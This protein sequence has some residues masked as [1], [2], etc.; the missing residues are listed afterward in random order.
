MI[1]DAATS[2]LAIIA[3]TGGKLWG[4]DWLDPVMGLVGAALVAWWARGLLRET[5]AALLDADMHA[6]VVAE[7][8]EAS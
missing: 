5:S 7:I 8:R 1:A 2:V 3:L 4:A 6:P